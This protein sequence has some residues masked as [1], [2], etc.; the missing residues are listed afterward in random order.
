MEKILALLTEIKG[1]FSGLQ[2][3]LGKLTASEDRNRTL[4]ADLATAK[5]TIESL[6]TDLE[7]TKADLQKAQDEVNAKGTEIQNLQTAVEEAKNKTVEIIASQGIPADQVPTQT[8]SSTPAAQP[9][10]PG[11]APTLKGYSRILAAF[12]ARQ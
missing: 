8:V 10:A 12:S 7:K 9:T 2:D 6:G 1:Y 4:E 5:Q 11:L 3:A